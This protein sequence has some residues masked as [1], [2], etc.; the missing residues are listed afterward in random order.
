[1][2]VGGWA[3]GQLWL[4]WVAALLGAVLAGLGYR[5]ITGETGVELVAT[6]GQDPET[7]VTTAGEDP[8]ITGQA[9]L[10]RTTPPA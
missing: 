10:N 5:Y 9:A 8:T 4:F 7:A 6:T 3:L 2:F 1:M